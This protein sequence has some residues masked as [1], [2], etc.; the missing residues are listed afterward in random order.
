MMLSGREASDEPAEA[1]EDVLGVEPRGEESEERLSQ[2]THWAYGTG[3]GAFR[4]LL[5]AAGIEGPRATLLH[6]GA[7]WG[8]ALVM[9]PRLDL[10]P[11]L[12]EWGAAQIAKDG[13][14]HAIYALAVGQAYDRM[15]GVPF[16]RSNDGGAGR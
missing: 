13:A 6:F 16:E 14:L 7:V 1:V 8:T 15:N 11:P 12:K 2:L 4:G 3:W 10:A 5:G 9:L